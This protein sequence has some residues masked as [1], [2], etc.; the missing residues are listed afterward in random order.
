MNEALIAA[1]QDLAAALRAENE[2]LEAMRLGQ[3]ATLLSQK[4]RAVDAFLR[5]RAAA[6]R[7]PR[8]DGE[9]LEVA[10]GMADVLHSLAAR[11]RT[12]LERGMSVQAQVI[13]LVAQA[14]RRQL[15]GTGAYDAGG[16][17]RER[18]QAPPLALASRA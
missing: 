17:A 14:A 3:A 11:N 5:A 12:L 18:G 2:A 4:T 9:D 13:T 15:P 6:A 10:R 1:A 16:L 8:P 7:G